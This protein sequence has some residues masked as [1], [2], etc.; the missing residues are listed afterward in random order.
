M[1]R[2]ERWIV[3]VILVLSA[4]AVV[5]FVVLGGRMLADMQSAPDVSQ[6]GSVSAGSH[7]ADPAGYATC[8]PVDAPELCTPE[9]LGEVLPACPTE[10]SDGCY[11]DASTRGN[12]TGR[13]WVAIDGEVWYLP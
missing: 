7:P 4:L 8:D 9:Q 10:D 6:S 5:L 2:A 11:W 12:G 13:S 1:S 3:G